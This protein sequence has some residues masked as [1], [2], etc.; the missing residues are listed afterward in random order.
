[1][2]MTG[3]ETSIVEELTIE[4]NKETGFDVSILEVKVHNAY[5]EVK[6]AR[7]YPK[8]YKPE[9]IESDMEDYYSNI[10]Y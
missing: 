7:N 6:Q 4:L 9:M 10:K 2:D 1:M 8:S 5:R 3:I